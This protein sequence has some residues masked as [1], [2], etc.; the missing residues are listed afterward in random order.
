MATEEV[1]LAGVAKKLITVEP[2]GHRLI[3]SERRRPW[4]LRQLAE[5]CIS[6]I[7]WGLEL[8]SKSFEGHFLRPGHL[9]QLAKILSDPEASEND[10]FTA[11]NLLQLLRL[12]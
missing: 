4:V 6:E 11:H 2:P 5:H 8:M 9:K 1:K 3:K 7:S 12:S 10:R